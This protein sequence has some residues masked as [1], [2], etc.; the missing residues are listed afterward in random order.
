MPKLTDILFLWLTGLTRRGAANGV[1]L[2]SAGGLGDTALFASVLPR[3][4]ALATRGE[5]VSVLLRTDGAKTAFLFPPSVQVLTL[6]FKRLAKDRAY[7]F[8]TFRDLYR[9]HYRVVVSTDY[10]RHPHLDEAL[11]AAARADRALAMVARPWRKYDA[12]LT[13]NRSL[14]SRLFDSGGTHVDKVVRWANFANWLTGRSDPLPR[15]AADPAALPAPAKLDRPTVVI[16]P[17]SAVKAKQPAPAVFAAILDSVGPGV[18]V[19]LTGAPNEMEANPDYKVLLDR[20]NV[21]FDGAPF[22]DIVPMLR[23]ATLVVSVDTALMHVAAIAG[24]PTLC[25]ASAAYVGEIVPYA[26]E[27]APANVRFVYRPMECQGCLGACVKPFQAGMYACVAAL[28]VEQVV[29]AVKATP[30][31]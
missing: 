16:Q 9:S 31:L 24:A 22:K 4:L 14:F 11:I 17:F 1:L 18:D 8:R 25:L 29:A 21:R 19:V 12:A 26:D 2:I 10:L 5:P 23:A 20:P 27:V 15:I 28:D 13:A 7:R 6:D 3:F 30:G